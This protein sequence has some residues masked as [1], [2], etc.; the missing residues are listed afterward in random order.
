MKHF[1]SLIAVIATTVF[2]GYATA[3]EPIDGLA[4]D[5]S[6]THGLWFTGGFM[7]V[8]L[9][10]QMVEQIFQ[11]TDFYQSGKVTDHKILTTRQVYIDSGR[12]TAA[13]IQTNLGKKIFFIT[14]G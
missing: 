2:T 14:E 10:E 5:F 11:K 13:L 1:T 7:P 4:T 9:P 3:S 12:Y 6:T 8:H